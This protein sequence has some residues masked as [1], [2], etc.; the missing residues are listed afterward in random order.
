MATSSTIVLRVP[1]TLRYRDVAVRTVTAAY[2]LIGCADGEAKQRDAV[3]LD[4]QRDFDAQ[5]ISAFSEI[6]N[7]IAIHAYERSGIGDVTLTLMPGADHLE[8]EMRDEGKPFDI[9]KVQAPKLE[10]LPESGM[11][12]HI[13][14]A[15]LDTLDYK[16][17]PP[18][19]WRLSKNLAIEEK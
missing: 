3:S 10:S 15:C 1:A 11:G 5:F 17:G 12:L 13:A 19:I 18:N 14:R 9:G 16:A 7:N 2:H 6:F 4:L 8:L